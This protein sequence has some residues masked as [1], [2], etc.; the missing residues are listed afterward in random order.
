MSITALFLLF[1]FPSWRQVS[2]KSL[3]YAY[4]IKSNLQPVDRDRIS[5]TYTL[6]SVKYSGLGF[7]TTVIFYASRI[8]F[9]ARPRAG[10]W[11]SF[12]YG[13]DLSPSLWALCPQDTGRGGGAAGRMSHLEGGWVDLPE[14]GW[15]WRESGWQLGGARFASVLVV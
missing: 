5:P 14:S 3:T 4:L 7:S 6:P 15:H 1:F 8:S 13:E 9:Q 2:V 10:S 12:G 11:L